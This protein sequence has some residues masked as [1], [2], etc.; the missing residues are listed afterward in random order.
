MCEQIQHRRGSLTPACFDI[1]CT[2]LFS[3]YCETSSAWKE[4][5]YENRSVCCF[6]EFWE[7][8]GLSYQRSFIIDYQSIH[9]PV[10]SIHKV[11]NQCP[12]RASSPVQRHISAGE[13]SLCRGLPDPLSPGVQ[14]FCK[15]RSRGIQ[16]DPTGE[17]KV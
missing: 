16:T 4:F 10:L 14:Y 11:P 13:P 15:C 12:H 2:T 5:R 17:M 6:D 7:N 3:M 1:L 8:E 9:S